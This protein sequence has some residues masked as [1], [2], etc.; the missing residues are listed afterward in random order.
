M[1]QRTRVCRRHC[2]ATTHPSTGPT[3]GGATTWYSQAMA[4]LSL[5]SED[6]WTRPMMMVSWHE[7]IVLWWWINTSIVLAK[8]LFQDSMSRVNWT[9]VG[10]HCL[11][12]EPW[13]MLCIPLLAI[14]ML[15]KSLMLL[16]GFTI[17]EIIC[18][19]LPILCYVVCV[20]ILYSG[21]RICWCSLASFSITTSRWHHSREVRSSLLLF[22][23]ASFG[24]HQLMFD[25]IT[26]NKQCDYK[27][28]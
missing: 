4:M 8:L 2:P 5:H 12:P 28:A 1:K 20:Y 19:L 26:A 11:Q 22:K 6:S 3:R 24:A 21:T 9:N 10:A 13:A 15:G 7:R 25:L 17:S 18:V 27:W 14:H 16:Y 23:Y